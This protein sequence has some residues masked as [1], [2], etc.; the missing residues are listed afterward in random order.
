MWLKQFP[1]LKESAEMPNPTSQFMVPLH[2]QMK[3]LKEFQQK[4]HN[5]CDTL[6]ATKAITLF[7]L[8]QNQ[9]SK[10]QAHSLK[11][12]TI[13]G[14][15]QH[16]VGESNSDSDLEADD[17]SERENEG[18]EDREIANRFEFLLRLF[19]NL[20]YYICL[21]PFRLVPVTL[22]HK[23]YFEIHHNTLQRVC[24]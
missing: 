8:K 19:V 7:S 5:D 6:D 21:V 24:A 1:K 23:A 4:G 2:P 17:D 10:F 9:M 20:G 15:A 12:S 14:V 11:I 22:D 16:A 18:N 13:A 3:Q